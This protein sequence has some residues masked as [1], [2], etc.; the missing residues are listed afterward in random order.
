MATDGCQSP[1]KASSN[2]ALVLAQVQAFLAAAEDVDMDPETVEDLL[3]TFSEHQTVDEN[4]E[5]QSNIDGDSDGD[6]ST[7][8]DNHDSDVLDISALF[9]NWDAGESY[10]HCFVKKGSTSLKMHGPSKKLLI[11]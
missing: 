7:M 8:A 3:E 2:D 1:H 10:M 6:S 9:G 5:V 11:C 4:A